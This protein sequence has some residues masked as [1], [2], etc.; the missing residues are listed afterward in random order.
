MV[1][2]GLP[3]HPNYSMVAAR[4]GMGSFLVKMVCDSKTLLDLEEDNIMR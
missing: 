1:F 3:D 2:L 4:I